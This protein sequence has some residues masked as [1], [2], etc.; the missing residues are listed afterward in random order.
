MMILS[1]LSCFPLVG[2][3]RPLA[4]ERCRL[5]ERLGVGAQAHA[6]GM[7]GPGGQSNALWCNDSAGTIPRAI[8]LGY[9]QLLAERG[10]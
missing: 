5:R 10:Q 2:S 1:G 4:V 3:R 7:Q 6:V 8:P 9:P